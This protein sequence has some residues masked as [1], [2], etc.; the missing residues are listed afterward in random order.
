MGV[1]TD[2]SVLIFCGNSKR[3]NASSF[4]I[5]D[6]PWSYPLNL[7]S[8]SRPCP[9]PDLGMSSCMLK[10]FGIISRGGFSSMNFLTI[11]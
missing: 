5:L 7:V 3:S 1:K 6:L 8:L 2:L 9:P 4:D 11:D 10:V